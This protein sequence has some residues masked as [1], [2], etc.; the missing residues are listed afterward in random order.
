MVLLKSRYTVVSQLILKKLPDLSELHNQA[1]DTIERA[2]KF[3]SAT[4]GA[5][6]A[7]EV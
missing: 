2:F 5:F 1:N 7:E 6:E 3:I 4:V